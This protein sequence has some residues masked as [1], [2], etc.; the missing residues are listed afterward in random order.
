MCPA[1]KISFKAPFACLPDRWTAALAETRSIMQEARLQEL[2]GILLLILRR[3]LKRKT[4]HFMTPSQFNPLGHADFF[5]FA[6]IKSD[7]GQ[8]KSPFERLSACNN[9]NACSVHITPSGVNVWISVLPPCSASSVPGI[10]CRTPTLAVL[11]TI[12]SFYH[13]RFCIPVGDPQS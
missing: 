5:S 12:S 11:E 6:Y 2:L 1:V 8:V 7:M 4:A 10:A 13:L 3:N 9:S